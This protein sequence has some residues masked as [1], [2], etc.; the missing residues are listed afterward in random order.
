MKKIVI[1]L[2]VVFSFTS[3]TQKIGYVNTETLIKE[4]NK[5]KD[6][7]AEMKVKAENL[8]KDLEGLIAGFQTKVADYQKNAN[9]LSAKSRAE[10][11]Q[12]LG[13]EQQMIQQKQQ[14]VQQQVQNDGQAAIKE[15]A[16]KVSEFVKEYA[17]KNGYNLILGTVELNGAVMY[18]DEKSDLTDTILKSL[19]DSYSS[20]DTDSKEEKEEKEDTPTKEESKEETSETKK[21]EPKK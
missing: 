8:Q 18:G 12:Q 11:E 6:V 21:E 7:E 1:L 9:K 14:Q 17:K 19:N 20:T 2:L 4:Y 16:E 15:I 5:T 13:Q 10:K 3:C